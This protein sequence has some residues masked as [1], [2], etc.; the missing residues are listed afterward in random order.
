MKQ[1]PWLA[2]GGGEKGM[3][4]RESTKKIYKNKGLLEVPL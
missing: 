1:V 3:W 2:S 4:V